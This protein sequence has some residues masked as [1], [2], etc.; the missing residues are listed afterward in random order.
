MVAQCSHSPWRWHAIRPMKAVDN[1]ARRVMLAGGCDNSTPCA[2]VGQPSR[3]SARRSRLSPRL[4]AASF[5]PALD[6]APAA[7]P[8]SHLRAACQ[9]CSLHSPDIRCLPVAT[10]FTARCS[11]RRRSWLMFIRVRACVVAFV[12]NDWSCA[13]PRKC[14][15]SRHR[16]LL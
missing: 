10:F 13:D 12:C 2:D 3:M 4:V 7:R 9:S 1:V 8:R 16:R 5:A 15:A 11:V 6:L 14:S